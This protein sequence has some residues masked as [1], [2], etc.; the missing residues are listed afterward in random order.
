MIEHVV[1]YLHARRLWRWLALGCAGFVAC[2]WAYAKARRTSKDHATQ[3]LDDR[4]AEL[5]ED[6][7]VVHAQHVAELKAVKARDDGRRA[8][9]IAAATDPDRTRRLQRLANLLGQK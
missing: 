2:L 8:E 3:A 9:V 1:A 5:A 6:V 7:A 4:A